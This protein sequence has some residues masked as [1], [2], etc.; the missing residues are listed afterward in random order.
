M[1]TQNQKVLSKH[2]ADENAFCKKIVIAINDGT[3][4]GSFTLP[5][6]GYVWDLQVET[7]AAIPGAPGAVNLRLGTVAAG[8]QYLADTDVKAQGVLSPAVLYTASV[9]R[10]QQC[11]P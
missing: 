10:R 5:D 4:G 8:Q 7:P 6:G 11:L 1:A 3:A 9:G 2:G